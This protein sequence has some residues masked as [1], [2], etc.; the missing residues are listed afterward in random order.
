MIG[1]PR[2]GARDLL[3]DLVASPKE[4]FLE[5][6]ASKRV[7]IARL[8]LWEGSKGSSDTQGDL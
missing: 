4:T 3:D 7:D 5:R 8:R 6:A 1:G 2:R